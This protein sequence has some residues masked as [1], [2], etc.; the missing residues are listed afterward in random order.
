MLVSGTGDLIGS[1]VVS[2]FAQQ[3][4]TILEID[5]HVRVDFFSPEGDTRWNIERLQS[6]YR[7][8]FD[9]E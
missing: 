5:N 8:F 2:Y 9:C 1:E 3:A 6:W 4:E 7:N